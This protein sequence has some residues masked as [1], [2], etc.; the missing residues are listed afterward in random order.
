M[1]ATKEIKSGETAMLSQSK[2]TVRLFAFMTLLVGLVCFWELAMMTSST[3]KVTAQSTPQAR[4]LTLEDRVRYQR[5]I[6]QV[7]WN[8]RV[9]PPENQSSRPLFSEVMP[10]S[11]LREQVENT[12]RQSNALEKY[13]QRPITGEQLQAELTR[14]FTDSKDTAVLAEIST[15]LNHD[16]VLLAECLARPLVVERLIHSWY[17][18]DSRFHGT[19]KAAIETELKRGSHLSDLSGHYTETEWELTTESA[20]PALSE[21]FSAQPKRKISAPDWEI[22]T[23]RL[24]QL[25]GPQQPGSLPVGRLSRLHET[26]G[27]YFVVKILS[28]TETSL[29][30]AKVEWPKRQFQDWWEQNQSELSTTLSLPK[31]SYIISSNPVKG[32]FEPNAGLCESWTQMNYGFGSSR[33]N[34]V[35]VWTGTEMIF[36]GGTEPLTGALHPEPGVRYNPT[37]DTWKP[38]RKSGSPAFRLGNTAIWTGT[39]MIVWGGEREGP[40]N[41]GSRYN[42]V[43]DCWVPLPTVEAP[44]PRAHHLAVWTGTEMIIW[45][46]EDSSGEEVN[47]GGRFNPATNRWT[48]I[49]PLNAP[50]PRVGARAVWTGSQMLVWGGA[51]GN[52]VL[53][54]GGRYNPE[55]NQ[56]TPISTLNAPPG[57]GS[58][59][60]WTGTEMILW[61][62]SLQVNPWSPINS[63]GRYNPVSDTWVATSLVNVPEARVGHTA[64]WTGTQMIVW[65]GY[66][67]GSSFQQG[68]RYNPATNSWTTLS[69]INAPGLRGA[70]SAVWTGTEM[71]IAGGF[72]LDP[73]PTGGRY[74]PTSNSWVPI[75]MTPVS[76]RTDHAAV[77]TGTE[78]IIWAGYLNQLSVL[79]DKGNR[80]V[81]ATDSWRSM[82]SVNAPEQFGQNI[83]TARWTGSEMIVWTG[84]DGGRYNPGTNQW[85]PVST[86]NA[87]GGTTAFTTVWT[88]SELIVWGGTNDFVPTGARYNPDSNTWVAVS[89]TNAPAGRF[90]HTAVWTGTEM[91][92]W[93]GVV[94]N[95]PDPPLFTNSG[96][97]YNPITDSWVST[98]TGTAPT[99]DDSYQAV[100]TGTEM[101]VWGEISRTGSRYYP[102]TNSWVP[103]STVNAPAPFNSRVVWTG[104]EM[105]VLGIMNSALAGGHYTPATDS[106]TALTVTPEAPGQLV[107]PVPRARDRGFSLVWT[108]SELILWGGMGESSGYYNIGGRYRPD[109]TGCTSALSATGAS[110]SASGGNS[111][112][113]VYTSQPACS[114]AVTNVP[115]WITG[116][117][118]AGA[119]NTALGFTVAEN[120]GPARSAILAIAG[121]SFQVNQAAARVELGTLY[122]ADTGNHRVQVFTGQTWSILGSGFGTNPG[123]FKSPEAV[124]ASSNGS[125]I[126]VADTGNN[127]IQMFSNGSWSV[128]ASLGTGLNQVRAPQGVA[129]D[130][131][132]NLYVADTGNNRL[133]RFTGGVPGTATVLAGFGTGLKQ[134]KSPQGIAVDTAFRLFIADTGNSRVLRIE[135][136][137]TGAGGIGTLIARTGTSTNPGQVRA[138]QGVAIDDDLN[139]YVADTGNNRLL[140][141]AGGAPG[142][143]S[144]LAGLG[145]GIGSVRAPEGITLS[146]FPA[147]TL[148]G[149][150]SL[151]VGDT[152]NNRLQGRWLSTNTPW[153]LLGGNGNGAGQFS[154]PGKIR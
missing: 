143:V 139:L 101:L 78:M 122:V 99:Q 2:Y 35:S 93:A 141:F 119:G 31:T 18:K 95:L 94:E 65:G 100:W 43:K 77:W 135:A 8:H 44:T 60:V 105:L 89:L 72:D 14:I 16:P 1:Q 140:K 38:V 12:L 49:S 67:S 136:A 17:A 83:Y 107:F 75:T 54:T 114:W 56:W 13:W 39:E 55:L 88:G 41:E 32:Q 7:Y 154:S 52:T 28:Q 24:T 92:I 116:F 37:T 61:G 132:G 133:L 5:A 64:V 129:L 86:V 71:L 96:G 76:D 120:T 23:A 153:Q 147:G 19:Q 106:W 110:F 21:S 58:S 47:T 80:Y 142:T 20:Q 112:V 30:F 124:T 68:G 10:D 51:T 145:S 59:V 25:A 69:D 29:K 146:R 109:C 150:L 84:T 34:Q 27:S 81:P 117:S 126:Y 36:W 87:P 15:Q 149:G 103:I 9:W 48:S 82:G 134:V 90:G 138:P 144:V 66:S 73:Y 118:T 85:T 102:Q 11:I 121:H 91:I 97:R 128:F 3:L 127:R 33:V 148:S 53:L 42:P 111:V 50:S 57:G 115:A 6:E 151:I 137:N 125:R 123:Q 46:G 79:N 45:G 40:V 62:G 104:A 98:D 4:Q 113:S 131:Q 108:G 63:G 74:N 26:D 152:G 130:T 70:H 22:E